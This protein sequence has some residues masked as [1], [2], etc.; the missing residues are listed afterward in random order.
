MFSKK[1]LN[2]SGME[3]G[4]LKTG[5]EMSRCQHL[6]KDDLSHTLL[7][8]WWLNQKRAKKEDASKKY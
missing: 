3:I 7:A 2:V 8:S 4:A 6:T 1:A 5:E